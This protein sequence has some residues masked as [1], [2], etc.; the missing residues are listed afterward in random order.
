M[1]GHP[2]TQ[3]PVVVG[4]NRGIP[5]LDM[6]MRTGTANEANPLHTKLLARRGWSG[7]VTPRG[8]RGVGRV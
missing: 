4:I 7:T 1:Y 3:A 8:R 5:V 6:V 2:D